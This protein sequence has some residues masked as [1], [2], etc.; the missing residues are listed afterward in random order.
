MVTIS[1][2]Y[3]QKNVLN[4]FYTI[5]KTVENKVKNL[6]KDRKVKGITEL[7]YKNVDNGRGKLLLNTNGKFI[8]QVF[9][10]KVDLKYYI[11]IRKSDIVGHYGMKSRK[12]TTASSNVNEILS[13][14]FLINKYSPNTYL[15]KLESNVSK[16]GKKGTGVLNPSSGGVD[17]VS[18]EQLAELIDK[19]ETAERD[20]KIG[21]HN[22]IAINKDIG[23][24]KPYKVYWCPRGKPP[25]VS[26]KNP[27]DVVVELKKG[28]YQGYSNKISEGKDETPKFNTNMYA[29]FGKLEDR[30]KLKNVCTM[31][32]TAWDQASKEIPKNKKLVIGALKEFDIRK[33]KYSESAS[34][35]S[36][37]EL[38]TIFRAQKLDFYTDGFYYNFRNNVIKNL[39]KYLQKPDNLMYF[40]NTVF[41]YTYADPRVKSTPCPYKL[42][43]G[44][45]QGL[46]EMKD[47]SADSDLKN[48]LAVKKSSE[49]KD[50]KFD[51][52]N[53]SQSFKLFF[54][55]K[56][57]SVKMPVTCR[58]R[59][60]G[61]WSG[62]SLFIT[63]SGLKIV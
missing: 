5:Q 23:G 28:D 16:F 6:L 29:Y 8:F 19:D 61:G 9:N 17:E 12:D 55:Y 53:K 39:G 26:D 35:A 10:E 36:F 62:K 49:L 4:P 58:T 43:I 24:K 63:T 52:D 31:I 38:A 48:I 50:I 40:L 22:A 15:T 20:I 44:K 11:T 21:F 27:S 18:Y 7:L 25:G 37:G 51:Y 41:F 46:S 3:K 14:F 47:V 34:K 45:E 32:D 60:A 13:V 42:L 54:K 59:A 33:E 2:Y 30:K 57:F 1:P 56:S